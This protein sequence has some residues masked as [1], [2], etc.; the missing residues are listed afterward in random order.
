M[1]AS[2]R[3]E[4]KALIAHIPPGNVLLFDRGYPGYEFIHY[5]VH[6]Y[7]GDFILR[8]PAASTFPAVERFLKGH[9][10]EGVKSNQTTY[11]YGASKK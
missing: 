10:E 6:H 11:K 7:A 2:E 3:E 8:C 1:T 5:L 9:Q 4:A